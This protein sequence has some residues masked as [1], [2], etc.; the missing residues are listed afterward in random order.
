ML[1]DIVICSLCVCSHL[2]IAYANED[3]ELFDGVRDR[4]KWAR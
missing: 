2:M 4:E 1:T 3:K